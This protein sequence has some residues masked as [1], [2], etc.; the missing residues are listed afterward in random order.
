MKHLLSAFLSTMFILPATAF[1]DTE[2]DETRQELECRPAKDVVRFLNRFDGIG[3]QHRDVVNAHI[4]GAFQVLD[5]GS[6]PERMFFRANEME[7][8]LAITPEGKV[9]DFERIKTL[10]KDG[11]LCV[12]DPSR[13]GHPKQDSGLSFSVDFE[14]LFNE[15]DGLHSLD[16]IVKASK[17]AKKFYNQMAPKAFRF[18]VPKMDHLTIY[19]DNEADEFTITALKAG[20]VLPNLVTESFRTA[21][22]I[23]LDHLKKIGADS[24]KITGPYK[25]EPSPSIK[26]MKKF[27]RDEDEE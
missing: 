8:A 22:V 15:L 17:D 20:A 13:V 1:A 9:P 27:M 26:A 25:M 7:T 18:M 5:D 14:L 16:E 24:L 4:V 6:W 23:S 2:P 3:P 11:E 10:P 21:S 12:Q 19:S